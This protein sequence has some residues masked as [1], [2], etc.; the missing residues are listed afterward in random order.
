MEWTWK[1]ILIT[2]GVFV[3]IIVLPIYLCSNGMMDY[4]QVRIDRDPN[5]NFSRW[6][7]I[8]SADTCY[9]T[10]RPER[11]VEY[12]RRFLERYPTDERRPHAKFRL[13]LSLEGAGRN[14]DAIRAFEEFATEYPSHPDRAEADKSIDRIKYIKPK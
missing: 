6:L 3:G 7:Q 8:K 10:M 13:A 9:N 2:M 4:Y 5:T 14:A 1:K 11:S 12:Y